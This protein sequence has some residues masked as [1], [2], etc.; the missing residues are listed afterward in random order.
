MKSKQKRVWRNN[1][2][3][4]NCHYQMGTPIMTAAMANQPQVFKGILRENIWVDDGNHIEDLK[5]ICRML[6]ID[7]EVIQ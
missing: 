1:F 4:Q 6:E 7:V 3:I 5:M 2:S